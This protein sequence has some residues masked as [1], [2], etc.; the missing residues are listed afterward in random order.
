MA[1]R[2]FFT[3]PDLVDR[4]NRLIRLPDDEAHHASRVL[5][6][7]KGDEVS[8]LDG[9]SVFFG[10]VVNDEKKN[11]LIRLV[12]EERPK[13]RTPE[14]VLY[15][16]FVKGKKADF[17]VEKATEAGADGIVFFPS[18][19]SVSSYDSRKVERLKKVAIQASKQSKR[20][21]PPYIEALKAPDFPE[22]LKGEAGIVFDPE[23]KTNAIE[24]LMKI[25]KPE[26]IFLFVGPEGG[27][28]RNE[29][30]KFKEKGF[31]LLRLDL[32]VLRAETAALAAVVIAALVFRNA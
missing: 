24:E 7:K 28:S 16:A 1:E 31:L 15:Q 6:L 3:R 8:V 32:P 30:K 27:F 29:K 2:R 25:E 5:R 20:E 26:K 4:K 13:K 9:T 11:F 18:E 19:N 17:V 14:I 10:Y 21:Y 12:K 23:G 22:L